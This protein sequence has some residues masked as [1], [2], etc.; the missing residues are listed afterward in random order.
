MI[1]IAV[2]PVHRRNKFPVRRRKHLWWMIGDSKKKYRAIKNYMKVL[3]FIR[4]FINENGYSPT[5]REIQ[6]G[7]KISS[8]S[9]VAYYLNGLE[10]MQRITRI[11]RA[12]RTI[13]VL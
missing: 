13:R 4:K 6:F 11:P 10:D 1:G 2:E 7:C 3:G 9:V 12:P 5:V 8:T